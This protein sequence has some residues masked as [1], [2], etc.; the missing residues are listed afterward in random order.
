[1]PEVRRS[2]HLIA[3]P[4]CKTNVNPYT[5]ETITYPRG[6]FISMPKGTMRVEGS[7]SFSEQVQTTQYECPTCEYRWHVAKNIT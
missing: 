1:M 6:A 5:I 7:L 4:G 3:C 2:N